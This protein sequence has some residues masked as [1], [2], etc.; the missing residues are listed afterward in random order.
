ML[1]HGYEDY[2]DID[3]KGSPYLSTRE[4][5][6]A[7]FSFLDMVLEAYVT[8]RLCIKG[9]AYGGM[10]LLSVLDLV[11]DRPGDADD[12]YLAACFSKMPEDRGGFVLP[13]DDRKEIAA[14]Y[15]HIRL[16][17]VPG[18]PFSAI[19]H[20]LSLS[21][22]GLIALL[23][24]A[25]VHRDEKHAKIFRALSASGRES[26]PTVGLCEDILRTMGYYGGASGAPEW[27]CGAG[28]DLFAPQGKLYTYLLVRRAD[29]GSRLRPRPEE[30]LVISPYVQQLLRGADAAGASS[31]SPAADGGKA[32]LVAAAPCPR[33]LSRA[34]LPEAPDFFP[35]LR[36]QIVKDER[37]K[38]HCVRLRAIDAADDGDMICVLAEAAKQA[39]KVL[40]LSEAD[41]L[42]ETA[43][44]MQ[45]FLLHLTLFP[46]MLV[47]L[48][49]GPDRK[50]HGAKTDAD[51]DERTLAIFKRRR[52][53]LRFLL[54]HL[55]EGSIYFTEKE[56]KLL[57]PESEAVQPGLLSLP[58]PD[59]RTRKRIWEYELKE[60][61]LSIAED[62]KLED[63]A[64]CHEISHTQIAA[65]TAQAR[66]TLLAAG[67][68]ISQPLGQA[69]APQDPGRDDV[70]QITGQTDNPQ[71]PDR[72]D[73]P[74]T[75]GQTDTPHT[76]GRADDTLK[77]NRQ[78]LRKLLFALSETD[79]D[80]LATQIPAHYTWEDIFLEASA[81]QRL[82]AACDRFRLRHRIGAAWG[83]TEKNAYGNAVILL[84][85]GAPGTGKTMAAQ[86]IANEVM[87]PLYR[88]DVSQI[89][90]KYIGETQKN[91]SRIFDEAA[92]RSVVLFFDEADALF[93]RRTDIKDSHDKY[94]NSDTSF[95]LQKVEEYNGISILAT[96][97]FQSFD[98]AF[99]RRITY[100]AHF[101][102]P[103]EA[104][105]LR[106]WE[107]MLPEA[108]PFDADVDMPFL[109]ER[110]AELT[111]A[112]INS[113]LLAAA[114]M[115]G[116]D[117][118]AVAMRD[119]ITAITYEYEKLGRLIDSAE[120]GT[121][122]IYLP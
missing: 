2:F 35:E 21:E 93:T 78:L 46:G 20:A 24:A 76:P 58:L 39:G 11:D 105:R 14:A 67:A 96:N 73:A 45:A 61:G 100:A 122:A 87:L 107:T 108:V 98:P 13:I 92:K 4:E 37:S 80:T 18:M 119:I 28:E 59:I 25:A 26:F 52:L 112:N 7:Y 16:R 121:Y 32:S 72:A 63:I 64:D 29:E 8:A 19:Q 69:V 10:D 48:P 106:M 102:R 38:S 43:S 85:Y 30:P 81:M 118:R 66:Q 79:F 65:V 95:L 104:T 57:C 22:G 42:P 56:R 94:A 54:S 89:F 15:T 1:L 33:G 84:M 49:H 103:D 55:T 110:F 51:T 114:Y 5:T 90:S 70:L 77:L 115:A 113:I 68:D 83:I 34:A 47:L 40:Y 50:R 109:A 86:A 99:M 88:V 82:K 71:A 101:E 120:F 9:D 75:A 60:A 111:G 41:E 36:A 3:K 117:K 12:E 31:Q 53:F 91:L 116:A 44:G 17:D 6:D 62:V 74:R 97:N 23:L 27:M